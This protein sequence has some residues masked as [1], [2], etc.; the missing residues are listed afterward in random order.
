VTAAASVKHAPGWHG[1]PIDELPWAVLIRVAVCRGVACMIITLLAAAFLPRPFGFVG[2]TVVTGSM[3]PSIQPGDVALVQPIPQYGLG[4]VILFPN[5]AHPEQQTIHRIVE[6][7]P[8][9][10]LVTKG[11]ANEVRDST[12]ID[13]A[14]VIGVGR[15]LVPGLG[16]PIVWAVNGYFLL[17]L[18]TVLLT[19]L[20]ARGTLQIEFFPSV[21]KGDVGRT[22]IESTAVVAM[23]VVAAFIIVVG[24]ARS[25]H[26]DFVVR[27]PADASW[28]MATAP[29]TPT[30]TA[31]PTPPSATGKLLFNNL[32][33]YWAYGTGGVV[34]LSA[35]TSVQFS[36]GTGTITKITFVTTI[37]NTGG[38]Y[39]VG[40]MPVLDPSSTNWAADGPGKANGTDIVY[41]FIWTGAL[42][43]YG[44]TSTLVATVPLSTV[45]PTPPAGSRHWTAVASAPGVT[46][47]TG[48]GVSTD[49]DDVSPSFH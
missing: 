10:M 38:L 14:T 26:A 27:S 15:I 35:N 6:I 40:G 23:L 37:D 33:Y 3:M 46:S 12:P 21:R 29:P 8:D 44:T 2:S 20:V 16:L 47:A 49:F 9:G 17:V 48:S 41:T 42:A 19:A 39:L 31:T 45:H 43:P 1:K 7:R 24:V 11:D 18:A 4:Q 25:A 34:G 36:E 30:P 13:P 32:S 28:A 22:L 5:P